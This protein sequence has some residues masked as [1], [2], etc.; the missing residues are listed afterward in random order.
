M[1]LA[2]NDIKFPIPIIIKGIPIGIE[3][4]NIAASIANPN[5]A[6]SPFAPNDTNDIIKDIIYNKTFCLVKDFF[7]ISF[8]LL[9]FSNSILF[10]LF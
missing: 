8:I 1:L 10:K 2:P 6:K 4:L 9:F 5:G 3:L 7:N